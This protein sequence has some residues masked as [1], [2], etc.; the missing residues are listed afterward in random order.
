MLEEA[1]PVS[2]WSKPAS[3]QAREEGQLD[4]GEIGLEDLV[5][6]PDPANL[7]SMMLDRGANIRPL[8]RRELEKTE[9]AIKPPADVLPAEVGLDAAVGKHGNDEPV[10][11]EQRLRDAPR[12][13][14]RRG[15][16]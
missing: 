13:P 5:P 11:R 16:P 7:I 15:L 9:R 12:H 1:D 8:S 4:L 14:H 6:L 10:P 2:Q 3:R